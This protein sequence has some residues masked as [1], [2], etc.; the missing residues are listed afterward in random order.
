MNVNA[1]G[2]TIFKSMSVNGAMN[3]TRINVAVFKITSILIVGSVFDENDQN[4]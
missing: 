2:R 4:F 1:F 3:D